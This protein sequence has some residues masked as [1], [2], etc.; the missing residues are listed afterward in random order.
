M[1]LIV[2]AGNTLVKLAV[3]QN[4]I[5]VEKDAF[6][7]EI[8]SE[9]IY[10]FFEKYPKISFSI[11][12]SVQKH[13]KSWEELLK[14]KTKFLQLL[15]STPVFFKNRYLSKNTLGID[16]IALIA[17]AAHQY[18]N[19]NVLVVDAG[20]CI[21]YDFINSDNEYLGGV[22]SPGLT[23]RAR[24]MH[25]FTAK[26]PLVEVVEEE[27]SILGKNT[28]QCLKIGVV[29]ATALEIDG[30]ISEYKNN[31]QD[32]TVI[33]TGG[34]RQILSKNVKN[35]IFAPSNF[36]LEGLNQILEFNKS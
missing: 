28:Q 9:K 1:N 6:E 17:N 33:L 15:S 11:L 29:K 3:F 10:F 19:K 7:K 12:S 32:L 20:T 18:K 21:T 23:M 16:R 4:D 22:I 27:K 26:L 35:S 24:A 25:E 34:D 14:S 31:F 36:L 13:P 8:F 2:D 30:F 5:L